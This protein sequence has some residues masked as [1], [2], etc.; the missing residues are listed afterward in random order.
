MTAYVEECR[1][2]WRRLGVPDILAEEMATELEAD[3]AE[4]QADG[5]STAEPPPGKRSRKRV[6]ILLGVGL[7]LLGF[8][9][10]IADVAFFAKPSIHTSG[11]PPE[12]VRGIPPIPVR[13]PNL[14][15]LKACR[16]KRVALAAGLEVRAFP[17]RRCDAVVIGQR[18][19]PGQVVPRHTHAG[20]VTFR[21]RG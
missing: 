17:S 8:V 7:V 4:A 10:G 13:V 21:L 6:W 14:V 2:E 1:R 15:G 5:V 18:P 16:A 9:L 11:S 19:V 20:T 12:R 3:L